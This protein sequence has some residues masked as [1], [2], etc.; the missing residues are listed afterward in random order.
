MMNVLIL[1]LGSIAQKHIKALRNNYEAVSFYA[2]RSTSNASNEVD[3][4]NLFS[5]DQLQDI[6]FDFAIISNPTSYHRQSIEALI[7]YNIPLFIEK[8]IFDTLDVGALLNDL[9][10]NE[11]ITYVAC[12][13]RFLGCIRFLKT[14]LENKRIN[15]VNAYCGSYLPDWRPG[16][17]FRQIYSANKEMGGGVHIDLIHEIDYISWIFG[18]PDQVHVVKRSN[19]SLAISSVDYANFLFVYPTYCTNIVLNYY[20]RDS[21]RTLEII[22]EDG[23]VYVDLLLNQII[24]NHE[25][26]Y[27]SEKRIADTYDDQM[28]FFIANILPGNVQFNTAYEAYEILKLCISND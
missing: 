19:S 1:G 18:L 17:D 5:F 25:V 3:V 11:V 23:T 4:T 12:N 21:K 13:L 22:L 2:L 24:Y 7:A 16:K 27:Q 14:F 15:E 6:H 10:K 8:P 28:R 26:I 9:K 20:R